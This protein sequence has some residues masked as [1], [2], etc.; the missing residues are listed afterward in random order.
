MP[1]PIPMGGLGQPGLTGGK[2][3]SGR[4]KGPPGLMQPPGSRFWAALL[5]SRESLIFIVFFLLFGGA[6][7]SIIEETC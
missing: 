5:S 3:G 2:S 7:R 4:G 6:C 1:M